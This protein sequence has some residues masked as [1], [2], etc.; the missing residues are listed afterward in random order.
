MPRQIET[1]RLMFLRQ[2]F[3]RQPVIPAGQARLGQ[4]GPGLAE[5][6]DLIKQLEQYIRGE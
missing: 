4:I 2:P 6:A 1:D 3:H 5:Q